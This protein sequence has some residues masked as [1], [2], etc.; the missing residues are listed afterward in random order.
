MKKHLLF[1]L[2]VV[3]AALMVTSCLNSSYTNN[4]STNDNFDYSGFISEFPDSVFFGGY[5]YGNSGEYIYN[6]GSDEDKNVTAGFAIS[7]K[8]DRSLGHRGSKCNEFCAYETSDKGITC[9]SV[10]YQN[11]DESLNTKEGNDIIFMGNSVAVC[12]PSTCQITNTGMVA[13]M[14][15]NGTDDFEPF[16][17]G[18][19][20]TVTFTG[21]I[22]YKKGNSV[23]FDLARYEGT[24]TILKEWTSVELK[25]I[26]SF[27][28]IGVT[29]QTNREGLPLYFCMDNF[30]TQI[31]EEG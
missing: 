11:P 7:A 6:V 23:T 15:I 12:V 26:G 14:I 30:N 25:D 5:F 2:S 16:K 3:A 28:T 8:R 1:A 29:L 9:F 19:Y 20:L 22:D 17:E 24:L 18:D 4:R 21:Y 31:T 27:T 13:D 10:Y